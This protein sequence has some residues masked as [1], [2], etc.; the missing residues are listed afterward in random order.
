MKEGL[1]K[2]ALRK[3][4]L[5][6]ED[7]PDMEH[8][9]TFLQRMKKPNTEVRIGLVGK[10]VELKDAYK[11]ISEALLHAGAA[12]NCKVN[13]DW[14]HSEHINST[15]VAE[16]LGELDGVLVA[17]G[18]GHRGLGGK[19]IAIRYVRENNLPFFGI[20]LGMQCAVIE[21][22]QNVLGMPTANSTEI[23]P[24]TAY[25]VIDL[26]LEQKGI[27][28][29]GGT[30]RLGAYPCKLKKDTKAY[31]AYGGESQI[32]ERHRHRY[33][34]NND[35]RKVFEASDMIISGIYPTKNLVEM[36]ELANH[37]WFVA[38]QFHPEY[39]STVMN[40]HPLFTGFVKAAMNTIPYGRVKQSKTI[41]KKAT[42]KV[43]N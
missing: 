16:L 3:L 24:D 38:S 21:Y 40:P 31:A 43:D 6:F 15:N 27:T 35:F 10:Y 19:L 11:S 26:M 18:F 22:A 42:D 5:P 2:I 14:I 23:N 30:M 4:H 9:K 37:P 1:D 20:C 7:A 36:I 25:P 13:I 39:K 17:P 28:E 32:K 34:F 8:W 29:K 41:A 33:E 12:N